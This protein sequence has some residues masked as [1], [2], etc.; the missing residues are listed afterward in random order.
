MPRK[1]ELCLAVKLSDY[2][3]HLHATYVYSGI[4]DIADRPGHPRG[5]EDTTDIG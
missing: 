3:I 5:A 2:F 1:M 4:L